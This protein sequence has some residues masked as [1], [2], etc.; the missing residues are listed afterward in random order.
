[1]KYLQE[2]SW[3]ERFVKLHFNHQEINGGGREPINVKQESRE[4]WPRTLIPGLVRERQKDLC[5]FQVSLFYIL[6]F[7]SAR[8]MSEF[9]DSL[10]YTVSSRTTTTKYRDPV[11]KQTSRYINN[12][13]TFTK[14]EYTSILSIYYI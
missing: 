5:E 12:Q 6:K 4:W 1:M 2:K 11:T 14:W 9:Y 7:R 13:W 8:S 10:G 3:Y